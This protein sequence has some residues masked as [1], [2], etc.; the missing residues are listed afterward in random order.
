MPHFRALF[1]L[2]RRED[3]SDCDSYSRSGISTGLWNSARLVVEMLNSNGVEAK[4][5]E[6]VDNNDIDRE[7][8]QYRPTHVFIEALWVVPEKFQVLTGLHP[9]VQWNIRMH[10]ELPFL[11]NEGIAM[12]WLL[13]YLEYPTV[14]ICCN[15]ERLLS[16][17]RFIARHKLGIT[18]NEIRKRV[19]FGPNYYDPTNRSYPKKIPY[20]DRSSINVG[21]F[22]AIRPLKNQLAQAFAA[23]KFAEQQGRTLNFFINVGRVESRGDSVL[24]N[25]RDLFDHL[26]ERGHRLVEVTWQ[27]HEDFLDLVEQLD[28]GMQVSLTET[29]NIVAADMVACKIPLVTSSEVSWAIPFYADPNNVDDIYRKLCRVWRCRA[30]VTAVNL[31][32]LKEFARR[33]ERI[34]L[35]MIDSR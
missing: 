29:F 12:N 13:R 33:S 3:Y 6:V 31:R 1:I 20:A 32:R 5:I 4:F 7:V 23:L 34:W 21:C 17:I 8:T 30:L 10:S 22:G 19:W 11:A 2:K 25:I 9:K 28:I 18:E 27:P 35:K 16:E 26:K 24:R 15:S 14:S